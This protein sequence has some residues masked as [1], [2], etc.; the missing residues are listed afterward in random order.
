MLH[1]V[2]TLLIFPGCLFLLFLGLVFQ[3]IDRKLHARLQNRKG[4]P[5]FQPLPDLLKLLGKEEI[6][7]EGANPVMFQLM[8]IFAVTGVIASFFYIPLW[9]SQATYSFYGD[10]I[11]V[12]YLLTI[13]TFTFFL[14]GWYSSSLYSMIG[15][16]RSQT[17]F[18]SYEVPLF[19]S[20]L[21]SAMLADT[22]SLSEMTKWYSNHPFYWMFNLIGFFVAVVALL[23]KLEKV[24]FDTPD[25]ETE[26]VAGTFTEYSGRLYA[27]FRVALDIELVVGAA[28]IVAVFLPFGFDL[29]PF[30]GFFV[31]LAKITFVVAILTVARSIFAR[32]RI[33]QMIE[34]CWIYLA[35]AAFC[36]ILLS[37]VVKG[38]LH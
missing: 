17:Q 13:P 1:D 7:P 3:F 10:V 28:L 24:P 8:P 16:M 15:A 30:P 32:M 6:I 2:F 26:I 11:V 19:M 25:A 12:I 31:W 5:W 34:F 20:V 38:A 18:F 9:N 22:W 36:Q 27:F 33:D 29:G 21:A 23:G 37:L 4:P 35:P 14:G